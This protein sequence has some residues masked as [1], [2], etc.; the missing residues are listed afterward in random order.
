MLFRVWCLSVVASCDD[1]P[2]ADSGSLRISCFRGRRSRG[3]PSAVVY[4]VI[5]LPSP[6]DKIR[7]GSTMVGTIYYAFGVALF[8]LR[9]S[10]PFLPVRGRGHA[11]SQ[12]SR[13]HLASHLEPARVSSGLPSRLIYAL[14]GR[15]SRRGLLSWSSRVKP[16]RFH[17]CIVSLV[18]YGIV[19]VGAGGGS[20]IHG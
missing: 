6:S 1:P 11:R 2:E 17:R 9:N 3:T 20:V 5:D 4:F 19:R 7:S 10:D 18:A 12:Q 14:S 13:M 8:F 15:P 16:S